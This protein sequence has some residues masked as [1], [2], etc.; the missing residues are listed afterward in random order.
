MCSRS[1]IAISNCRKS[2]RCA[3]GLSANVES[4]ARRNAFRRRYNLRGKEK[5]KK[6]GKKG[7]N[8]IFKRVIATRVRKV[9][10]AIGV[11]LWHAKD[12]SKL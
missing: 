6:G 9:P 8:A 1:F 2:L 12:P 3:R 10:R 4:S 5:K 11:S 7:I